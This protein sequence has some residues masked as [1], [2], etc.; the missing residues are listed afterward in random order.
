MLLFWSGISLSVQAQ[1]TLRH[2]GTEY[3]NKIL[4]L[5]AL[6]SS[7]ET[8]FMFGAVVVPQFKFDDQDRE[9]RSSSILFSGIYTTKNQILLSILPD[10]ILEKESW[11]LDGNYFVNYFPES[12]WGVGPF[13][14]NS[15]ERTV[16]YTQTNIEQKV[17][18]G[19]GPGLFS[20]PYLR[21]S[22]LYSVHFENTDGENIPAPDVA[23]A[24]GNN[25]VGLGWII[26]W[27]R[28]NSNM[29]PTQNH[30]IEFSILGYP[31]MFGSSDPYTSYQLDARKYLDFSNDGSA[32]LALQSLVRF[33]SGEPPFN[34]MATLGGDR[35]NRGYYSGRYRDQNSAQLQA[36]F[37]KGVIGRFG[38]TVFAATG[39]VWNK[40][41]DFT[42]RNYKWTAG[43]GFRFN[44]NKEDPTNIRIDYG[45]GKNTSGFYLQFGEAF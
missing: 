34:D 36:E 18:K 5:P 25:S 3:D 30:F 1:D 45:F 17:L 12:Y 43:G 33:N 9:T 8:G 31:G 11:V 27:D 13:T 32:V 4:F 28:R 10:I 2:A 7:P 29:T 26:R 37:R 22:R 39:E 38:F 44:L 42:M 21:W 19:F 14:S 20:G 41:K 16:L 24:D 15:E 35:I 23:G 40:F 6:G